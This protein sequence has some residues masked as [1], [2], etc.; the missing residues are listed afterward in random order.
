MSSECTAFT[1]L[2]EKFPSVN[3][4]ETT[5]SA[6]DGANLVSPTRVYTISNLRFQPPE[7]E[8]YKIVN[9]SSTITAV[10]L[11]LKPFQL[12]K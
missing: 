8:F 6:V 2:K 4:I 5:V 10:I 9:A 3:A 11:A 1:L 7:D 12:P